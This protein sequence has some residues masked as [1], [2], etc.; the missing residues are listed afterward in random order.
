MRLLFL[1]LALGACAEAGKTGL[2]GRPDAENGSGSGSNEPPP[3]DAFVSHIDAPPGMMTKTLDQNS[4]DTIVVASSIACTNNTTG[5]TTANS[6]YRVFDP[7]TTTT[8]HV[9]TVG[10]QVEDCEGVAGNGKAVTLKVGT[11]TGT[12]GNTLTT[13]S[14]SQLAISN[15]QVPEIAQVGGNVNAPIT[16]D[17]PAGMK[18]YVEIDAPANNDTFYIGVNKSAETAPAYIMATDCS[19]NTPTNYAQTAGTQLSVLMTVTGTY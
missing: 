14:M 2:G 1:F 9:T 3:P 4:N 18:M 8:F 12:P 15:V 10:F 19:V 16:A 7:G 6:Y 11:Y 13:G 17:I 5:F